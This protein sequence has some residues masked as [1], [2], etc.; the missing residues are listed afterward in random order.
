MKDKNGSSRGECG[1]RSPR[2]ISEENG[3]MNEKFDRASF[4]TRPAV[5]CL[6][7]AFCCLLWGSAFPAVKLG[8]A[9]L[10]IA[11]EDSAAQIM[12]AG[13]RFLIAGRLVLFFRSVFGKEHTVPQRGMWPS[14]AK[15]AVVQTVIQY[16]FFYVGVAN[17]S[18][19]RSSIITASNAFWAILFAALLFKGEKL[20][21]QKMLGCGL[22]LL[23]VTVINLAG[24]AEGS[25]SFWGEGAVFLAAAAN[26]LAA[27][28]IKSY[29]ARENPTILCGYQFLIGG[30]VLTIG[31]LLAGGTFPR[32]DL[33]SVLILLYLSGLSAAATTL[34]SLLTKYNPVGRIAVFSFLIPVFGVVLSAILL[35][36]KN[37]AFTMQG[38]LALILVSGGIFLVNRSSMSEEK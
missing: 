37:Q 25:L 12:Y 21:V 9:R 31:G 36:E 19:V 30:A 8:Y 5:V 33:P 22:G 11:A 38:L 7:A 13:L 34:W 4:F 17:T 10:S 23:G 16:F 2:G 32:F 18:G 24:L 29:A 20:G 15:L 3:M 35:Q 26:G 14:V 6:T 27:P 28:M 1:F